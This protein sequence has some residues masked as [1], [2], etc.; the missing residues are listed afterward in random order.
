MNSDTTDEL[1]EFVKLTAII[2]HS[3]QSFKGPEAEPL[4]KRAMKQ[5][6]K[7]IK[8][9]QTALKQ[10][11]KKRADEA[12]YWIDDTTCQMWATCPNRVAALVAED[13]D[14]E[15]DE[16]IKAPAHRAEA[17]NIPGGGAKQPK[18]GPY[19]YP[20]PSAAERAEARYREV[21]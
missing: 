1:K 12:Y 2:N 11:G 4:R 3:L 14:A 16:K 19:V 10:A 9:L 8:L 20:A 5:T 21:D 18:K 17:E 13:E 7:A 15:P 6:E